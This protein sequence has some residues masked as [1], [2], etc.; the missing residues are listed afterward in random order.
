MF[1]GYPLHGM[2]HDPFGTFVRDDA[3]VPHE[4][5]WKIIVDAPGFMPEMTGLRPASG[6]TNRSKAHTRLSVWMIGGAPAALPCF[7]TRDGERFRFTPHI[8][9]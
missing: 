8:L 4:P 1:T 9:V 7:E 3:V 5:L 2:L 6:S